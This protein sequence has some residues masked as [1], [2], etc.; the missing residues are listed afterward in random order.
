MILKLE[1]AD[2]SDKERRK[3]KRENPIV[4]MLCKRHPIGKS[5]TLRL[6]DN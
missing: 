2:K 6:Q 3:I 1:G 4:R 5:D